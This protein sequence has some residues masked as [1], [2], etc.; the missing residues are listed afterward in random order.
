MKKYRSLII[1]LL[2]SSVL[3]A[4]IVD[5][6]DKQEFIENFSSFN[7]A[8]TPL[9][10]LFLI[11]N[12]VI[13]S[14]RWKALLIHGNSDHISVKYL[15]SL[16]FIGAFF[17]NFMPTSMGGDVYKIY[18]LGKKI[19]ST[20]DAFSS[21]FMERF[22]GFVA[23]G[24]ISVVSMVRLWGFIGLALFI[25]FVGGFFVGLKALEFS[26]K[27]FKKLEKLYA[28]FLMYKTNYKVLGVAFVTS[29]VVQLLAIFTQYFVFLAL[30]VQL[31][32][33]YS[34]VVFPVI[35]LAGFFIPSLNGIGVQDSLYMQLFATVGVMTSL[36][37]GASIIYHLFRLGVSLV[38]GVMYAFEKN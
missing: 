34:L 21:T 24:L 33:L 23:L 25:G 8:Y 28:S 31:P 20:A 7:F 4:Y 10:I 18:Q 3:I 29:F 32:L 30:D 38:G 36:S 5:K 26:S 17:N 35:T 22:T 2:V 37:L 1:K 12:Y 14:Y 6:I 27:K 13:S 19:D 9:I 16:Y 15:T 11:L